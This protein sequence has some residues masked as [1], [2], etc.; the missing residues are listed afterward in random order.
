MRRNK[1]GS[2]STIDLHL[3]QTRAN[4]MYDLQDL[5]SQKWDFE[6]PDQIVEKL[7]ANL[8]KG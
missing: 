7:T 6:E 1:R 8:Q 5:V 3:W 4:W 2:E